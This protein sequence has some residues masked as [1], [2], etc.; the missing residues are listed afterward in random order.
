MREEIK[1]EN[2]NKCSLFDR[3]N[4]LVGYELKYS[5]F[6]AILYNRVEALQRKAEILS[7]KGFWTGISIMKLGIVIN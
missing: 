6:Y 7:T 1:Q 5:L 4:G 3:E 2:S